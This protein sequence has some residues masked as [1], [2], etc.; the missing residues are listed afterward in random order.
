MGKKSQ[1]IFIFCV[2]M[3]A[4]VDTSDRINYATGDLSSWAV[5]TSLLSNGES[6]NVEPLNS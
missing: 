5:G 3:F 4:S 6:E 1:K 2:L